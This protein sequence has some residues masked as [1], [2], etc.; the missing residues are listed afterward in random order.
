VANLFERL[1]AGRSA[2]AT[3]EAAEQEKSQSVERL[4]NWLVNN[5]PH[6]RITARQ[7]Y[8]RGPYPLRNEKKATLD[9]AQGLVERGWL[10]P[11]KSRRHDTRA[12]AIGPKRRAP[13]N[14]AV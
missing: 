12:W 8:S 3:N 5:W 9:L 13:Q 11:L 10:Y 14:A 6:D 4:L 7:V 2:P 1:D